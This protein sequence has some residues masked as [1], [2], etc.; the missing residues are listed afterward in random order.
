MSELEMEFKM[1][2][3]PVFTNATYKWTS[4]FLCWYP[5]I[6][7]ISAR[8]SR[9]LVLDSNFLGSEPAELAWLCA[10]YINLSE[11]QTPFFVRKEWWFYPLYEV[12]VRLTAINHMKWLAWRLNNLDI[13]TITPRSGVIC[14]LF[15]H[16][17]SDWVEWLQEHRAKNSQEASGERVLCLILP[18]GQE[19]GWKHQVF[20]K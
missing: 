5:C 17:K 13:I 2:V 16:A 7:K 4:G 9:V 3:N 1:A 10:R 15:S 11:T 19:W 8:S 12:V 18:S 6:W 14:W 20:S